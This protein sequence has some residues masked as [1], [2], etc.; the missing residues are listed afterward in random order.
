MI[1]L[2]KISKNFKKGLLT[3]NEKNVINSIDLTI[4]QGKIIGIV[5]SS[6]S[7]KTTLARIMMGILPPDKGKVFY[8]DRDIYKLS[9]KERKQYHREVQL[10]FQNPESALVPTQT[11]LDN[12]LAPIKIHKM[13]QSQAERLAAV[14]KMIQE[15]GVS[16]E[17]LYRYPHQIS[18]GE[19][20][21]IIICRAL[22]LNPK[23]LILDE[24]TS[25][26]DV[27]VQAHIMNLLRAIQKKFQLT[28]LLI[29][30]DLE[31]ISLFADEV[32]VMKDGEIIEKG[33][34]HELMQCPKEAYTQTLIHAFKIW[35]E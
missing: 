7:G 4:E 15:V 23:V 6:G 28:Y 3:K 14:M 1:R 12:L 11:V 13:F 22:L 35:E 17:L 9:K 25:M 24:P 20:Q 32:V 19:A 18:G 29:S 21:R 10:I 31:L 26:L 27:S 33:I 16:E 30:H 8:K 5:G 2:E 34:T